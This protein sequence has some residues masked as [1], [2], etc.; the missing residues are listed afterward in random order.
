ME[1]LHNGLEIIEQNREAARTYYI[2]FAEEKDALCQIRSRSPYY[3]TLN[4]NWKFKL[5][6][7]FEQAVDAVQ[8]GNIL[9]DTIKVPSCWQS[10]GY[11]GRQY[12]NIRYPFPFNPP[13]VPVKNPTGVYETDVVLTE[14]EIR[15]DSFIVFEGVNS[16]FYLLVNGKNVGYSQGSR[17]PSEFNLTS[18]LNVGINKICVIV[19]KWCDGSY[20]ED[21]DMWR[22]T[23]IFRDVYLLFRESRRI[24]DFNIIQ[25]TDPQTKQSEIYVHIVKNCDCTVK[26]LDGSGNTID[27]REAEKDNDTV[28]FHLE[29]VHLW[30]AETPYLYKII[31]MGEKE[32]IG[33]RIGLRR[34]SIEDGV[35]KINN[36]P[37]ILKG[38]NR[39]ESHPVYGQTIPYEHMVRD[40]RLM[41]ENNINTIRTSHYPPDVRFLDLC[42]E[43]GF[44]VVDENDLESHGCEAAG[45]RHI[46]GNSPQWK[47]AFIDRVSRMYE[48]D[49]NHSCVIMWSLGN[50]AGYGVNHVEMAKWLKSRDESRPVHYEGAAA[51]Y[52]GLKDTTYL[53]VNSR[54]YPSIEEME[55]Y[56]NNSENVKPL[57][58]CE[59]SHAMGL[60]PGDLTRYMTLFEKYDCLMGG[61]VWEWC[62][63]GIAAGSRNGHTMY[64]YGGDFNEQPHDGNFCIDGLCY[65]DRTAHTG[66][67]ELKQVYAPFK[68]EM[69]DV[70]TGTLEIYN[71]FDFTD[72]SRFEFWWEITS[73][74]GLLAEG[75]FT[76]NTQPHKK[77]S[78]IIEELKDM[79]FA[80]ETFFT[81]KMIQKY[82]DAL[83]KKGF[84][85]GFVQMA[86]CEKTP[87]ILK[88]EVSDTLNMVINGK[89]AVITGKTFTYVFDKNEGGFC[90]MVKNNK[91]ILD[92]IPCLNIWRAPIDNDRPVEQ[93][94]KENLYDLCET[95]VLGTQ[96]SHENNCIRI[97][98][99]FH[100]GAKS[101]L[102]VLKGCMI[103]E[104]DGNGQI[105]VEV[106]A[107]KRENLPSLPRLGFVIPVK[108][109]VDQVEYFGLGP[110]ENYI[111]LKSA[112]YVDVFKT[113][114][115]KMTE[116]YVRPQE[117]G[118]R[119]CVRWAYVYEENGVGLY[120]KADRQFS[121]GV[122]VYSL[123]EI[124][125][126]AHDYELCPDDRNYIFM[127]MAMRGTGSAACGPALPECYECNEKEYHFKYQWMPVFKEDENSLWK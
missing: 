19:V 94:W 96:I 127:D 100:F 84:E 41:K 92:G 97:E 91:E 67:K 116:H 111:D 88:N 6:E 55:D 10:Q 58:L 101:F 90:H 61:C 37:V 44:Y 11:D 115:Q 117:N 79:E 39:H 83:V 99:E 47:K 40:L 5:Y 4:G 56:A 107:S 34:V 2:P 31:L 65:P 46:L 69:V 15:E 80:E 54:M 76:I 108:K 63:H 53:D 1:K 105:T 110:D 16:C 25:K 62:D 104:I 48:R 28:V 26:I 85:K 38:V 78:V 22:Y 112:A 81:V 20:L 120:L 8:E 70:K 66:L 50:E 51:G 36:V 126:K 113:T 75:S 17:L 89:D 14:D 52:E 21:Q 73:C 106:A 86:L 9:W 13:H 102:P 24:T 68:I 23:G 74:R 29:N 98:V 109:A 32:V 18:Y 45:D 77:E 103:Y 35:F 123:S 64:N 42:D 71:R 119:S 125:H 43:M 12:T 7:S 93:M 3:R 59:Y 33:V 124:S 122:S 121:V 27:V 49:K 87:E 72:F 57:F 82:S 118:S 95:D 114:A 60:G 30:S